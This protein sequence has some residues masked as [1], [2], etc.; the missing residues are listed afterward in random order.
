[1]RLD[2][3]VGGKERTRG[4]GNERGREIC[5]RR[6]GGRPRERG[7]KETAMERERGRRRE[8]EGGRQERER[9]GGGVGGGEME[10]EMSE[11]RIEGREGG[12]E[13]LRRT[14]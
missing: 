14:W 4:V 1:M 6:Q 13:R 12:G 5:C 7:E 8:G 2:L 10:R 3:F 9:E 11:A